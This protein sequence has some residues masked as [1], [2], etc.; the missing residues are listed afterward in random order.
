MPTRWLRY[1]A[2]AGV[3]AVVLWVIG[4]AILD[5]ASPAEGSS[6]EQ[7][8][9][10][11][12]DEST[13]ILAGGFIFALGSLFFLW[14]LG[15]MRARLLRAEGGD[16]LLTNLVFG[17]GIAFSVFVLG[18]PLPD[19]SGALAEGLTAPAAQAFWNMGS[20]FF[21]GAEF[22]AVALTVATG[23]HVLATRILPRWV[24]FVSLALALVLLIPQIGWAGLLFGVPL[25]TLLLSVLLFMGRWFGVERPVEMQEE[26]EARRRAA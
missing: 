26:Q 18:L 3:V 10:N 19:M 25:W 14:F 16:G 23:I 11:Y 1:S 5:R 12:Q 4:G 9:A 21:I 15:G 6:A 17:S 7:I 8:L 20:I 13:M 22:M 2:L 24:G